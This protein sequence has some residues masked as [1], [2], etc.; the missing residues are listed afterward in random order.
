MKNYYIT[1]PI[2]YCND[3]PHLGHA[4][5]NIACDILARYH[6][7]SNK[8][9]YFLTGTDEHGQKVEQSAKL[10]NITPQKLTDE[11]S[12]NFLELTKLLNCTNDDFIRTTEKRHKFSVN[13]LWN[14]LFQNDQIYLDKYKG[15]YS[16]RDEAFFDEN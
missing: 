14:I 15:W 8:N 1:T 16:I 10:K 6:R 12:K 11:K 3:S 9:V 4:Y 13:K 5:T 2:Y 7:L